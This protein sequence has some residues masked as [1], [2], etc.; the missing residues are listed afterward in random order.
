MI[1]AFGVVSPAPLLS[2]PTVIG[3]LGMIIFSVAQPT[4]SNDDIE[5]FLC[6]TLPRFLQPYPSPR[7]IVVLDNMPFHRSIQDRIRHAMFVSFIVSLYP[8]VSLSPRSEAVGA[9]VIFQP[10]QSP[11]I[12]PIE[13]CWDVIK[14]AAHRRNAQCVAGQL[15]RVRAFNLNDLRVCAFAVRFTRQHLMHC[16]WQFQG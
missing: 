8:C 1:G 2:K 11:D 7:S 9:W 5:H 4:L 14:A 3:D 16:Q 12:N 13:K 10:A 15:G 6:V